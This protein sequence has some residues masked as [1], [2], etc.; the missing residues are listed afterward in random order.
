MPYYTVTMKHDSG[1]KKITTFATDEATAKKMVCSAENAPERAAIKVVREWPKIKTLDIIAW[2]WFDK[3]NG[4]S[5]FSAQ[6][7]LNQDYPHLMET[8]SLPFQYGYGDFYEQEAGKVLH[9]IG[10]IKNPQPKPGYPAPAL[11]SYCRDKKILYRRQK[12]SGCLKRDVI[13]Y[14]QP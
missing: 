13:R 2:E 11:W 10:A 7:T 6:I 9:E 12:V 5:Y 1:R 4:N 14:G 8:I 3:V